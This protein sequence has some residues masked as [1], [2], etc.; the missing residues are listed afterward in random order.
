MDP[1][2]LYLG[3][4]V[5]D[6]P[7]IVRRVVVGLGL[8]VDRLDL[9]VYSTGQASLAGALLLCAACAALARTPVR[10]LSVLSANAGLHLLLDACEVKWGNGVHL[11]AP[12]SWRLT[13]FDLVA[14]ESLT[15]ALLTLTGLL[16]IGWELRRSPPSTTASTLTPARLWVAG[17]LGL[18]YLAAPIAVRDQVEASGGGPVATLRDVAGRPG[19][20]LELDRVRYL[21]SPGTG[22]RI[23]L[24]TGELVA[25]TGL[26]LDHDARVSLRGVFLS[27]G[28]LR[29]DAL[30][31]HEL[32]RDWPS[33]AGLLLIAAL[34]GRRL[35]H[36]A[37]NE[38]KATRTRA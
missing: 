33:Y 35:R 11:L 38:P 8:P 6:V 18:A 29:I 28:E 30:V 12:F 22:G 7:W 25:T 16:L 10:V 36:R 23:R 26:E 34:W 9:Q 31:E 17:L 37:Q 19:R 15:N 24:W 20:T 2:W 21:H 32:N 5:P 13:R 1:R 27:P 14:H 3:C 4:L